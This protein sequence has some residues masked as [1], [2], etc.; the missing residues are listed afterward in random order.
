[1]NAALQHIGIA[2]LPEPIV[3]AALQQ[4]NLSPVLPD[5]HA[6]EHRIELLYLT[7][8]GMLPAVRSL[9]DFLSAHFGEAFAQRTQ[10]PQQSVQ[11]SAM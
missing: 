5:W 8:R 2:L 7:P 4:G 11:A 10:T 1:M 3:F 6:A 9:I